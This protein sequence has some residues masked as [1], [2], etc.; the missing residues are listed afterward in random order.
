MSSNVEIMTKKNN[1]ETAEVNMS[2]YRSLLQQIGILYYYTHN[3]NV[4]LIF[5]K[6][7][8]KGAK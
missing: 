8:N 4:V 2:F 7:P 3:I 6:K 1:Y 5:S